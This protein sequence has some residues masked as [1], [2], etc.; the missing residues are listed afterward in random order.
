MMLGLPYIFKEILSVNSKFYG[1]AQSVFPAG[2]V[3]GSII[4]SQLPEIS[5]YYKVLFYSLNM[6][7]LLL[8]GMGLPLIPYFLIH[9][10]TMKIYYLIMLV[11]F[12]LGIFNAVINVP[13]GILLQRLIPDN[14]RGRITVLLSTINQALVLLSVALTGYLLDI[15]L[16]YT[17]FIG[18]EVIALALTLYIAKLPAIRELD[19]TK[20]DNSEQINLSTYT[21]D[22]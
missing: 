19:Y 7:S 11:L 8:L 13:I 14:Q 9:T 22:A 2:A 3:I 18:G 5:N 15:L 1:F 12:I 10:A 16:V 4:L 20:K 17:L 6:Q 21:L